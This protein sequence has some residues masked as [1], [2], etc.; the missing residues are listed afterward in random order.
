MAE[1][2]SA[3]L[4]CAHVYGCRQA[5]LNLQYFLWLLSSV[6]CPSSLQSAF[7]GGEQGGEQGGEDNGY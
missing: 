3:K 5:T 6:V 1:R 2:E 7:Y 4:E